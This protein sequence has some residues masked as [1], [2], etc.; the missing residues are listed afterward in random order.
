VRSLFIDEK[1]SKKERRI[2]PLL[3]DQESVL[4]IPGVKLSD[5]ARVTDRTEKVLRAEII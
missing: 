5:R 3:V 2:I 4:W 1:I